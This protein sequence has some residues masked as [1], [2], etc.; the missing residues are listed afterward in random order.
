MCCIVCTCSS[1]YSYLYT[2][3]VNSSQTQLNSTQ[4]NSTSARQHK[5]F[6][7]SYLYFIFFYFLSFFPT[8]FLP[9]FSLSFFLSFPLLFYIILHPPPWFW[10]FPPP[11]NPLPV[12]QLIYW[13]ID[14]A[15]SSSC[16]GWSWEWVAMARWDGCHENAQLRWPMIIPTL[17]LRGD[18]WEL[19]QREELTWHDLTWP[20][21]LIIA[22]KSLQP[23]AHLYLTWCWCWCWCWLM[24]G[25]LK[26]S[27]DIHPSIP[28]RSA[29]YLLFIT[30][31]TTSTSTSLITRS[32]L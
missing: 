5:L 18:A 25:S 32:L 9:S 24:F 7:L 26:T 30:T 6:S 20:G 3:V 14:C 8:V 29:N 27:S 16:I 28:R 23:A 17:P 13:F 10:R 22:P 21:Y 11:A 12:L 4:L 1:S 15:F 19:Q 2:V 31:T